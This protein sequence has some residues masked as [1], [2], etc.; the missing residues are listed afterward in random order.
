MFVD[1]SSTET[2]S[3]LL[4]V[5]SRMHFT[6]RLDV[7]TSGQQWSLY[8]Y[9]GRL[10]WAAGGPHPVRRWHRYMTQYC[11]QLTPKEVEIQAIADSSCQDLSLIHI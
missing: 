7:R 9:M 5:R 8:L 2:P 6:G 4:G 10:I 11:P 1:D 3:G